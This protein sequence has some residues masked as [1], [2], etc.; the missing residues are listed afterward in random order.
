MALKVQSIAELDPALVL[1]AQAELSQLI[2]ERHPEVELTRGVIHDIVAF[3]AGG[4][5]GAVNQT[6]INRILES[7]SLLAVTENP[8]LADPELV[9]HLLS[10]FLISRKIGTRARGEITIVVQGDATVVIAAGARY[11]ANGLVYLVDAPIT[12]RPS[13]TT[14]AGT[15][16]R[17]LTP[18]GDGT[19]EFSVPA[20]AVDVGETGNTRNGTKFIPDPPPAR[21]VTAF[22]AVD[23]VGGTA[24]ETNDQL[25]NR[26]L[27]G[28]PAK[29]VAGRSNIVALIKAQ[30]VFADTKDY[31]IVGYGDPEMFRD[32]HGVVPI[33]GG[34]RVDIYAKTEAL[35]RQIDLRKTCVLV[36]RAGAAYVWQTTISRDDAPGFY[37][38]ATV[39]R[40]TDPSDIAGLPVIQD[41]RGWDVA[42]DQWQPDVTQ[43]TEV[44]Y[45]RYQTAVIRFEDTTPTAVAVV[46]DETE[47]IIG[48]RVQPFIRELQNFLSDKDHRNLA[49]DILVRAAVPCFVTVNCYLVKSP[50]ESSPDLD[51]IRVAIAARVNNLGF[52]GTLYASQINE[53]V[54]DYLSGDQAVSN[55]ELL[56]Q[57]R[58]PDGQ[59]VVIRDTHALQIPTT[60]SVGITPRTTA[61]ML[62]PENVGLSVRNREL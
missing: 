26:M 48:L 56:G 44:T 4:I 9:D 10:N 61:F 13:G 60:P 53:T 1:Q 15:N 59:T 41:H 51:A 34:G 27:D 45:S 32:R 42:T 23:F 30:P 58:R 29:V 35:P 39:R 22:S 16:D 57:I 28:I 37:D 43:L 46:G 8:Q 54:H 3:F 19:Y 14:N 17:I 20:T 49:G 21:F 38:V 62:Y 40:L 12:A 36:A 7:R 47:Y 52:V 55:I 5:S 6:E 31:S 25:V 2:Q 50:T 11:T 33:S 18:R 24:T